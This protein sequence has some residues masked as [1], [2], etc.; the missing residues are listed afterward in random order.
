MK[1]SA[2]EGSEVLAETYLGTGTKQANYR[3]PMYSGSWTCGKFTRF[4]LWRA[5]ILGFEHYYR[6]AV[7]PA[8]QSFIKLYLLIHGY[9]IPAA[10]QTLL[11][12]SS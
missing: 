2:P 9:W 1:R 5:L 12:W 4:M 6:V 3:W 8:T 10:M 11:P 7:T